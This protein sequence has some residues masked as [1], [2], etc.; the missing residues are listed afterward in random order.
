VVAGAPGRVGVMGVPV[1]SMYRPN[2]L[3]LQMVQTPNLP[4]QK[5]WYVHTMGYIQPK[6]HLLTH[7]T[8]WMNLENMLKERSQTQR[9]HLILFNICNISKMKQRKN[10][11]VVG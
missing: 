11:L 5:M 9:S 10:G 8:T 7:A 3:V 4:K 1:M 6:K 2:V